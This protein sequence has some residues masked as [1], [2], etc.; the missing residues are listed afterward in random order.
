MRNVRG[1]KRAVHLPVVTLPVRALPARTTWSP[2]RLGA[3]VSE[4]PNSPTRRSVMRASAWSVP[5]LAVAAAAPA[6]A[7]SN[8]IAQCGTDDILSLVTW[9]IFA[10]SPN[11]NAVRAT[12]TGSVE[13]TYEFTQVA[14]EAPFNFFVRNSYNSTVTL[15]PSTPGITRSQPRCLT[16]LT[17]PP[18][19]SRTVDASSTRQVVRPAVP[20]LVRSAARSRSRSNRT[21]SSSSPQ[22]AP[23]LPG[24][25]RRR[26]SP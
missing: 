6:F 21:R 20:S 22:T 5:V 26:P 17:Q 18:P 3:C 9:P 1:R 10:T 23:I 14:S 2:G 15:Q 12:N 24:A 25:M 8:A 16:P 11:G 13:R 19:R 7:A 4:L